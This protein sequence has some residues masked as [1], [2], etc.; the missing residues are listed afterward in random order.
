MISY[1]FLPE[2]EKMFKKLRVK[3]AFMKSVALDNKR[4]GRKETLRHSL[5]KLEE[6]FPNNP[7]NMVMNS[8]SWV[9]SNKF[10]REGRDWVIIYTRILKIKQ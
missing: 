4:F 5:K 10:L 8:S 6:R 2:T 3:T 1:T 7:S 9:E